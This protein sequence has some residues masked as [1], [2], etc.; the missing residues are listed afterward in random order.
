MRILCNK[1]ARLPA[2][3]KRLKEGKGS[4]KED[5]ATKR[6]E[7]KKKITYVLVCYWRVLARL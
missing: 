7:G 6:Q 5:G 1:S 3:S 4:K 2:R